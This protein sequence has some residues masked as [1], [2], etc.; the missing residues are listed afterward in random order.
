MS[1][2]LASDVRR[3][4]VAEKDPESLSSPRLSPPAL[5]RGRAKYLHDCHEIAFSR[6]T[7]THNSRKVD[8]K[9]HSLAISNFAMEFRHRR[10]TTRCA[11]H[12]AASFKP[13][14]IGKNLTSFPIG[15]FLRDCLST[16]APPW[17]VRDSQLC[18]ALCITLCR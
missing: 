15:S 10:K 3:N 7:R 12:Y 17:L 4:A 11:C 2:R 9:K 13:C 8:K 1:A 16:A 5:A 6:R 14:K 18:Q